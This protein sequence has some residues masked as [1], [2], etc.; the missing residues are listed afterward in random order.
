MERNLSGCC[1]R[2]GKCSGDEEQLPLPV[3]IYGLVAE[4]AVPQDSWA[5]RFYHGGALTE[6][7]DVFL[8]LRAA[9]IR[10]VHSE[11]KAHRISVRV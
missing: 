2:S 9:L 7:E 1:L 11:Q 5:G 3:Q 6:A 4:S 10:C 8:R